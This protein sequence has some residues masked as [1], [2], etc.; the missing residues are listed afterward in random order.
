VS[1]GFVVT[2]HLTG[3]A[4]A[5]VQPRAPPHLTLPHRAATGHGPFIAI[6]WANLPRALRVIC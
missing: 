4:C 6:R 2:A 1:L 3:R 5:D